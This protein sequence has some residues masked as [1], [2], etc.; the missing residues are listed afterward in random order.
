LHLEDNEDDAL[1]VRDFLERSGIDFHLKLVETEVDYLDALDSGSFD[2]VLSDHGILGFSGFSALESA[3]AKC[4]LAPFIIVSGLS[5]EDAEAG[6]LKAA[7]IPFVSKQELEKLAP[8]IQKALSGVT[9]EERK[10]ARF[11]PYHEAMER[12]V[13]VVQQ[14]SLTRSLD[15]IMEI[16]R[17]AARELTGADGATFVLREGDLCYYAEEDAISPLWKGQRFPMS[18]CIS[19]WAML[20]RKPAVIPDIYADERIPAD[21]YRPT[22]VKS[23]VMVPIRTAAPIGA[24]GNYWAEPCRPT[25]EVVRVLQALADTT[26]VAV[27]NV[28]LYEDLERRVKERTAELE[29]ANYRLQ[30]AND[31]FQA[32]N[33]EMAALNKELETFTYAVSHDLRSPLRSIGIF[34]ENLQNRCIEVLDEK[35]RDYLFR[36]RRAAGRMSELIDDLL[37]LSRAARAPVKRETVDMSRLALEVLSELEAEG[38]DRRVEFIV[39][40]GITANGDPGLIRTALENLLGN[41]LK[42][43]SK[44][45]DARIEFGSMVGE[46]SQSIYFVRDNGAGFDMKDAEKLFIPF[47]RLHA[48]SDFPGTGVGLATVQRIIRKHGGRI[49]ADAVVNGGATFY[50]TFGG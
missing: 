13:G 17:H 11:V 44:R 46:E 29:N 45:P 23:L 20:N 35:S 5:P 10:P 32:V 47:Q 30:V 24:I 8:E 1:I 31:R 7:G 15:S 14:L 37:A 28:Q 39:S 40:D 27:E 3:R 25:Q 34:S 4:P 2:L 9:Q 41:A 38:P 21:A 12:L 22:F 26:S 49:W 19:G 16:V 43:A 50:F 18:A 36:V 42:Y 33:E 6:K 48:A